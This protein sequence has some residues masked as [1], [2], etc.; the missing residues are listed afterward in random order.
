MEFLQSHGE[1]KEKQQKKEG[2]LP[3]KTL[4]K[5]MNSG[6]KKK[7]GGRSLALLQG[8]Q[9]KKDRGNLT[10]RK[11]KK[12]FRTRPEKGG[13]ALY[14][15]KDNRKRASREEGE[16]VKPFLYKERKK[17]RGEPLFREKGLP[18]QKN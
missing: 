8:Q 14:I 1:R 3:G 12:V 16:K 9:N 2:A 17:E 15:F 18:H 10:E 7:E 11:E 13:G 6:E 5:R 4:S